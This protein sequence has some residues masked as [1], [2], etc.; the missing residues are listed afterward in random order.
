MTCQSFGGARAQP[1]KRTNK[2][3]EPVLA[4][5]GAGPG[6]LTPAEASSLLQGQMARRFQGGPE[7][8]TA[9]LAAGSRALGGC[10]LVKFTPCEGGHDCPYTNWVTMLAWEVSSLSQGHSAG[11]PRSRPSP[12]SSCRAGR[13]MLCRHCSI[14]AASGLDPSAGA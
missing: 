8:L 4:M 13:P 1:W 2:N 7:G 6:N 5:A 9:H 10:H 3:S 14:K 12:L 11:Q